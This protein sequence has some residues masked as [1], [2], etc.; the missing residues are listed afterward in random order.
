MG[1][2]SVG[3]VIEKAALWFLSKRNLK[4]NASNDQSVTGWI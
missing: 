1:L 2:R 4:L 3:P